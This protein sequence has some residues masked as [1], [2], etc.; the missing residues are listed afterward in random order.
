MFR[1]YLPIKPERVIPHL[2]LRETEHFQ[3]AEPDRN[4]TFLR[5]GGEKGL[6][7]NYVFVAAVPHSRCYGEQ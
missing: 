3:R 4:R 6:G 2:T 5:F 1:S 7:V